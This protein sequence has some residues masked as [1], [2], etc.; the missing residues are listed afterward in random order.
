MT[1]NLQV[2]RREH[3]PKKWGWMVDISLWGMP[4]CIG[5]CTLRKSYL[6]TWYHLKP[7]SPITAY[8]W[9]S[10]LNLAVIQWLPRSDHEF[11]YLNNRE[12]TRL[13]WGLVGFCVTGRYSS[14]IGGWLWTRALDLRV[15]GEIS[16]T[17]DIFSL[18]KK[19]QNFN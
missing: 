16:W 4:Q 3:V 10:S 1:E 8:T 15:Y 19:I 6:N 2:V 18:F 11:T 14:Y 13:F 7:L 5:E 17:V 9:N 12:P